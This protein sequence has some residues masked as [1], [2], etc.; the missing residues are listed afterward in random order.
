MAALLDTHVVLWYVMAD[1]R[2]SDRAKTIVDS[3][4][5]LF[6]SIISLWEIAI[7]LSIGKLQLTTSFD[8]LLRRVKFLGIEILPITVVDTKTYIDLP[9]IPEHR[10][11]FDRIL[12][13]QSIGNSLTL[14]S[15]DKAF[16]AY[17]IQ[18]IWT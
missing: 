16:D 14:V 8:E 18:R 15:R 13:A 1:K 11:P 12:V 6:F 10:D 5:N 9:F 17:S 2:L 7:K 4:S 3:R